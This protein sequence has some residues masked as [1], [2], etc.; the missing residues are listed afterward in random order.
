[1][2]L[3]QVQLKDAILNQTNHQSPQQRSQCGATPARQARTSNHRCGDNAELISHPSAA[4]GCAVPSQVDNCRQSTGQTAQGI[5]AKLYQTDGD[6]TESGG[7]FIS[8]DRII[9][10]P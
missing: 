6:S 1:M 7:F 3:V 10:P 2:L 5:D 4:A 8:T 9:L